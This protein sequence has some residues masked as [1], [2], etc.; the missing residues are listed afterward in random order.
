MAHASSRRPGLLARLGFGPKH[1]RAPRSRK[2]KALLALKWSAIAGL[3]LSAIFAATIALLFWIWGS[4]SKLPTIAKLSDYRPAQVSRVLAS[5]GSVIGEIYTQRRSFVPYERI[6]KSLI[7]ALVSAEDA[8]FFEHEGIDYLGM[9]RALFVNLKEGETVQGAS[10]I[11][12]QVVKNLLLSRERTLKRKVQEIIL[13]RRLESSLSKDEILTLY[14]NEIYFGHG[15]YGVQE[16]ARFYFG[17]DVDKLDVGEVAMLAGLPQGPEIL[18]PK[19]PE[20]RNRAKRRQMYVLE[21]MVANG[22]LEPKV[23]QKF[24]KEPIRII[25]EPYPKL[26]LAPEWVDVARAALVEKYGTEE[27]DRAGVTVVATLDLEVQMA[28]QA[29]LRAGLRA[30]D[31]RQKYGMPVVRLKKEKVAGELATLKKRLP[32]GGPVGGDEY[33]AVVLETHDEDGGEL[34]VDLGG[35]TASVLLGGRGD[36][37]FNPDGKKAS[38]RFAAGDVVR[39]MM[40]R[41][42]APPPRKARNEHVVQLAGGPEGAVVVIEPRTRRVLAVVGGYAFSPGDFNRATMARRQAG[43][44]F[45]PFVYAAAID[46]GEMTPATIVNDAPEVYDLWKPENYEK[47]EFEGPVRIR[48]ALAKSINTVAIRVTNDIGPERVAKM[49]RDMGVVSPLP[50]TLSIALGSGEVT[51][52]ELTNAFATF[53]AG[54]K[55]APPQVLRKIGDQAVDPVALTQAIRPEVAFVVTDMMRSVVTEGTAAAASKALK[56]DVVGKTGTSNSARDAWFVGMTGEL[57]VG[58]WIGF[59]DFKRPLGRGEAGGKTALPVF[60]DVMKKVGGKGGGFG[61]PSG[62][63]DAVIDRKTGLLAPD[64][65]PEKTTLREVF[66]AGTAP[67]EVAPAAGDAAV[68]TSVQDQYEDVYGD[69]PQGGADPAGEPKEQ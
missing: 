22:Y 3:A 21:Q 19:K 30:Y 64:G 47:G 65:A 33:R 11:T 17:K 28:A 69:D 5:D 26:G 9:V 2:Q 10:T 18:S 41:D 48:H 23:A 27:V 43:S 68:D 53:A 15:R 42:A 38:D 31:K 16:A 55:T 56:M 32:R 7:H 13:S 1:G 46:G 34:A 58:V 37:R 29:A 54:G 49:A 35:W 4:D 51:P 66:L 20:N 12:Q 44:T 45:K 57:V 6:P 59:D 61:R 25:S 60:I 50:T 62:V 36:E 52:L 8:D 40:P 67:T 14:A 39:V 63:V 24:M